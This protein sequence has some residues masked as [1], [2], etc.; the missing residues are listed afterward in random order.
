MLTGRATKGAAEFS[1]GK[2]TSLRVDLVWTIA[3]AAATLATFL[4]L[5]ANQFVNWANPHC[6]TNNKPL[7]SPGVLTWAFATRVMGHYQP[8][9]WLT[10]S[11]V[12]SLAGM[13]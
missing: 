11:A 9:A 13:S 3:V 1:A 8:L 5:V 6:P 10:W 7:A 4:P 2:N 12:N